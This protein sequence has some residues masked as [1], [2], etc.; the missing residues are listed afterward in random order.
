MVRQ[1]HAAGVETDV[2]KIEGLE[3]TEE[4]EAVIKQARSGGRDKVV[5][6]ILGRGADNAQVEK[7][8]HA[9]AKAQGLMGFAIGRSIFHEA[10][11]ALKEGKATK[12]EAVNQIAKN[13]LHFY[14]VFKS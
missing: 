10:L 11:M 13:Y 6:V 4:Y 7:W 2:W 8:L 14:E 1:F 5:A 3:K 12:E 9:A